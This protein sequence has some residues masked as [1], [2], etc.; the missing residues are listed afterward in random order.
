M[1]KPDGP[2]TFN[3]KVVNPGDPAYPEAAAALIKAQNDS[4]DRSRTKPSSGP[5]SAGAPDVD[6]STFEDVKSEDDEI[7]ERI[8]SAFRF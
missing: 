4:R 1:G 5:I 7:L 8:R 2:I 6:R 3:G